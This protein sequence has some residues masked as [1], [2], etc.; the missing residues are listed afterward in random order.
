MW[1]AEQHPGGAGLEGGADVNSDSVVAGP[2]ETG[3]WREA[4]GGR[5]SVRTTRHPQTP[6]RVPA[7]TPAIGTSASA[8][9][10]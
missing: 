4:P 9:G 6:A 2:S 10:G 7:P 3:R 5:G 1:H 8:E